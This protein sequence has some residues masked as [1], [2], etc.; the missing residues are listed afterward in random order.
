MSSSIADGVGMRRRIG[1]VDAV[2]LGRLEDDLGAD[3]HRAQA[4]RRVGGEVRIAGAGGEDHDPALLEVAGRAP[5][6][7]GLGDLLDLDRRLHARG[8]AELLERVLQREALM[9]VASMPM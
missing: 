4:R 7:V 6:D 5:A 9:T 2:D 3:L 8:D 1:V